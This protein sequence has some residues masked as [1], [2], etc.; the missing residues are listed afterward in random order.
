V[1]PSIS[2]T[3][4]PKNKTVE[5]TSRAGATVTYTPPTVKDSVNGTH[6]AS[7]SPP[8]GATFPL[9]TTNVL[10][11]ALGKVIASF[12]ITVQDT[13]P[14][15]F[16][17]M[18][19]P[20]FFVNGVARADIRYTK[21][22]A[23]DAVGPVTVDGTPAPGATFPLGRNL[24]SCAATDGHG[25]SSNLSFHLFVRDKTPPGAVSHIG[26]KL[27][28]SNA[29]VTWLRPGG[30]D[31]VSF[32]VIRTPGHGRAK[33]S[34]VYHGALSTF[35]D[36][37]LK[38]GV[39]YAYAVVALDRV[40]NRSKPM[41]ALAYIKL[42]PLISPLNGSRLTAPPLLRWKTSK[43]ADYYNVQVWTAGP[44]GKPRKKIFS[45]WPK[46][47][48]LQLP[49]SWTFAGGQ[50]RL[51]PGIYIWFV[52]PGI[53]KQAAAKYGPLIGSSSFVIVGAPV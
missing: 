3:G 4:V 38:A 51:A 6:L 14:P 52:W 46:T 50:Q 31:A 29:V 49:A 33:H 11:S 48:R 18:T 32:T 17:K 20:I 42:T 12:T 24:V 41:L 8:S 21:P 23:T 39:H 35:T 15:R 53:G 1:N 19:D 5:A 13:T 16:A 37:G 9:G 2:I 25:N 43:V 44:N 40:G 28:G 27:Q 30:T 47:S 22:K 26:V 7:C 45:T 10:C 34:V 36:S